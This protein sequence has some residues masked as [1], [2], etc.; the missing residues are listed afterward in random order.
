MSN[1]D[2]QNPSTWTTPEHK[3]RERSVERIDDGFVL[4]DGWQVKHDPAPESR[5]P[6]GGLPREAPGVPNREQL[7]RSAK[8][9]QTARRKRQ[10]N[11]RRRQR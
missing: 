2:R 3:P 5:F 8:K 7:R 11:A 10:R 9:A 4:V 6:I 1:T